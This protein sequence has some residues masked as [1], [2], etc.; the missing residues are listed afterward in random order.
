M[1]D[2]GEITVIDWDECKV[3]TKLCT[4]IDDEGLDTLKLTSQR[5]LCQRREV[6]H[7]P[8]KSGFDAQRLR[9]LGCFF[10]SETMLIEE[11]TVTFVSWDGGLSFLGFRYE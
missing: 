9:D 11:S 10:E 8:L 7:R 3:L 2:H 6:E 5:C 1:D 4:R